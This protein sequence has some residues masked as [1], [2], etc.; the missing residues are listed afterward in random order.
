MRELKM[1]VL[2]VNRISSVV[3]AFGLAIFCSAAYSAPP[4]ADIADGPLF[5]ASKR[6]TPNMALSLSVEFPTV[7]AAYRNV[8]YN[9]ATNYLGYWDNTACYAYVA[10]VTGPPAVPGF[11]RRS[12]NANNHQCSGA[13]SGNMLNWAVSSAIDMLRLA[14]T[15]GD[16]VIDTPSQTVLQR[17]VIQ[18]SFYRDGTYFPGK[19]IT[20]DVDKYTPFA[21]GA[22]IYIASCLDKI[23]FGTQAT[24]SCGAPSQNADRP[25]IA[26]PTPTAAQYEANA[27]GARV[28]V[29]TAGEGPTRLL[30]GEPLCF[31]YPSGN[32]K[33][34]GAMQKYSSQMR[35]AA[36]GYLNESGNA[37]YGGVLRAPMKYVGP[38][39]FDA[40][41]FAEITNSAAEWD[42]STGVFS[43]NPLSNATPAKS[44]VVNYLN[45]FGRTGTPGNY[46]SN[47]PVSELYYEVIRYL[48]G[49]Q[50]T[51]EAVSSPSAAGLDGYPIYT[52]WTDPILNSC[53]KNY[54]IQIADAYTHND[55]SIPGN[56]RTNGTGDWARTTLAGEFTNGKSGKFWTDIV[57]SFEANQGFAYPDP[58]T[59]AANQT[60]NGNLDPNGGL[61]DLGSRA[62]GC[63]DASHYIAGLA[64]F[65]NT[66]PIRTDKPGVRAKTFV[67]N[68]DENGDG[69]IKARERNQQ[70]YLAAKYGGFD[71]VNNDGSP[72]KTVNAANAT[73]FNNT[74]WSE[75]VDD[76]AKP[77]P[78]TFFLASNP[79]KMI[80]A[81]RSIFASVAN[82]SGTISGGA[83]ST[84]RVTASGTDI[85]APSFETA[86][87][88][89]SV[90]AF[91]IT[92]DAGTGASTLSTAPR[93]D[94]GIRLTGD[95]TVVPVRPARD[96]A[97]RN[98]IT[99]TTSGSAVPFTYA[100]LDATQKAALNKDYYTG[101]ADSL[102]AERVDYL[103][104]V[105]T[106]EG[107]GGTKFRVRD[108]VMGDVINS[109]P[110]FVSKPK[111]SG[112]GAGYSTFFTATA[113]RTPMVYIG[114][115]DGMMHGIRVSDGEE[116]FAFIPPSIVREL[117]A[118]AS[119]NYIHRPYVDGV[120]GVAEAQVNGN[121]KSILTSGFGGGAQGIFA[122]DVT[123][124]DAFGT[125]NFLWSFTDQDD[126]DIGYVTQP[127]KL[128]RFKT[129]P[130][131]YKWFAVVPSGYNNYKADGVGRFNSS[132][133]AAL[134]LL[135]LDKPAT[136][137]WS[138][139][140]NYYKIEVPISD[141]TKANAL[142]SPSDFTGTTE[143]VQYLYAGDIQG[144]LWKFN[145]KNP[146]PWNAST[147]LP[148]GSDPLFVAKDTSGNSQPITIE[149]TVAFG[150][151]QS[152]LVMFGT[153]KF[154]EAADLNAANYRTQT[155]YGV[156]D[157]FQVRVTGR[158]QLQQ[159]TMTATGANLVTITGTP[160]D[161]GFGTLAASSPLKKG[162]YVDV[163]GSDTT[164]ERIVNKMVIAFNQ[165]FFNTLTPSPDVCND[166]GGGRSCS[167]SGLSGL[168]E[169]GT[170][171]QSE[172]GL[173][174]APILLLLG[175]GVEE[176]P[177]ST[178][179]SKATQKAVIVNIGSRGLTTGSTSKA[180][181]GTIEAQ[182]DPLR[183]ASWREIV[184][185]K[186]KRN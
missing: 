82:N 12:A 26:N 156:L 52:N 98:L 99:A 58:K 163:N 161:Y 149:P 34:I 144:N 83:V 164:G 174:G 87:W 50:P 131:T 186:E 8:D 154:I 54:V 31:N 101:L 122:L 28:E 121:W 23:Y 115:N 138:K 22:T 181:G 105:R 104:G 184:D 172:V 132:G 120:P 127:P 107:T 41:T 185:F 59:P 157:D 29:C 133:R 176:P 45:Q 162:W 11:F 151:G 135:S 159:R 173:L 112:V 183:R 18:T 114:S 88:S 145:F 123:N 27:F 40:T 17:A 79:D 170:C 89:G 140:V 66:Q 168:S 136:D 56:T 21:A 61:S 42:A 116:L 19:R 24:G 62:G 97:T 38:K 3:F 91:S 2:I 39:G 33:P 124:P 48:Q 143:S 178:G 1:N 171:V 74:E 165:L 73:V 152:A 7:G 46:K 155:L 4:L 76:E 16:R 147:V 129:A 110:V 77:K 85:F 117:G 150:P 128:L 175:E 60:A 67:I 95:S 65:A 51:L 25:V 130:N 63:C 169:S 148:F 146:P 108:S 126:P 94:A 81:I 102:G 96:P 37:R 15:G 179:S 68:V 49:L 142:S 153:G 182:L 90:K 9:N 13:F 103:R 75:G 72:F 71:D 119:P 44:G 35:F 20:A 55:K 36:F 134:F 10:A 57:G 5:A 113:S 93:W 166:T 118:Y 141:D 109:A 86:R 111:A 53:Q 47:D 78:K 177:D 92:F 80:A 6:V 180:D 14:M 100:N 84:T 70:L 137:S 32:Y 139:D 30:A 160:F 125:A 69:T 167:I 106:N 64:Y 158:S 43:A